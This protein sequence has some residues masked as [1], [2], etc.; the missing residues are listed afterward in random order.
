MKRCIALLVLLPS[1]I[2]AEE[3]VK[4]AP[5]ATLSFEFP[6]LPETLASMDSG[7]KQPARITARLP[8]NYTA[9]GKYPLFIYLLGGPGGRGEERDLRLGLSVIGKQ[10][11][12]CVALPLFKLK[13]DPTEPSRGLM[14][15]MDDFAVI[16][17]SY[18]VML[19]K[20]FDTVPNITPERSVI[21]G[22]SNGAHTTGVLLAGQDEFLFE[23]FRAF[24]LQEGG[25][26]PLFAN[27]MQKQTMKTARFLIMMGGRGYGPEPQKPSPFATLQNTL[28]DMVATGHRDFTF[29][30]MDGYGHDQPPEYLKVIGQWARSQPLDDV[31]L[32]NRALAAALALPLKTHPDSSAWPDLLNADISNCQF[33][34][35]I[36]SFKEGIL[37]AT[38]DQNLWTKA[39]HGDCVLDLEFKLEPGAN[40]GVFLYNSAAK[41]WMSS[42][43]EIQ[44]CDD[45]AKEWREKPAT[46]HCGAFFGHQAPV[47]SNVK[48]AGEWNRMT[49][50]AQGSRLTVVINGE[51]VNEVDLT[52]WKD[53]QTNPDGSEVPKWLQG[54]SW[55]TLPK[56]GRIGFQGRHAGAGI[57]FR[58]VKL[59]RL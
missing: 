37:S 55:S 42:S 9:D 14:V 16:A 56:K 49:I 17:S 18:R 21:G 44:I 28:K 10:D 6:G 24:Y 26:G 4:L 41:N 3:P 40:S 22:H 43:V 58:K 50:T 15:S 12:I 46:W 25:I 57:E 33:P 20:L 23:H 51:V 35:G 53:G 30:T 31:T 7:K 39:T 5:N 47:K 34:G 1:L 19:Q 48:P 27:V 29:I 32:N 2:L 59:L 52:Q 45:A 13:L 54:Q 11:F 38:E 36:W 8:E